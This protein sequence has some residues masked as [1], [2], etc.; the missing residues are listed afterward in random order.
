MQKL[1]K[2][3]ECGVEF[4]GRSKGK[5]SD[6]ERDRVQLVTNS[7]KSTSPKP[8]QNDSAIR[9]SYWRVMKFWPSASKIWA[10]I[11]LK[12]RY[13]LCK[14]VASFCNPISPKLALK[15]DS[16]KAHCNCLRSKLQV[17][18]F[19][20]TWTKTSPSLM[21]ERYSRVP[22]LLHR[23]NTTMHR[24]PHITMRVRYVVW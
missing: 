9:F 15:H 18:T 21:I 4:N 20:Y 16:P 10:L 14:A 7:G 23:Q 17:T 8:H 13:K 3:I 24:R 22:C 11:Q 5:S 19:M 6:R 12:M 1:L 2:H